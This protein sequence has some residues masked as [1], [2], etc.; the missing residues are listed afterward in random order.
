M[1]AAI[2]WEYKDGKIVHL[3]RAASFS[4]FVPPVPNRHNHHRERR[5]AQ[6]TNQTEKEQPPEG[7]HLEHGPPNGPPTFRKSSFSRAHLSAAAILCV[8]FRSLV[9]IFEILRNRAG[10]ALLSK[11]KETDQ[12]LIHSMAAAD[13][14]AQ[15]A[16]SW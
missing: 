5:E 1:A 4:C 15:K 7:A 13:K 8:K 14:W 2:K 9:E 6:E 11:F 3:T 12:N 16:E 10:F